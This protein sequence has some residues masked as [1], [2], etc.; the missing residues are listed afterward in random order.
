MINRVEDRATASC[1]QTNATA[2]LRTTPISPGTTGTQRPGPPTIRVS[3]D[4]AN[5]DTPGS[6][7]GAYK[8][9]SIAFA[10]DQTYHKTPVDI[11]KPRSPGVFADSARSDGN[12][13]TVVTALG[14]LRPHESLARSL[15]GIGSS[16]LE[17]Q[18]RPVLQ[19]DSKI[20][21]GKHISGTETSGTLWS[22]LLVLRRRIEK[23]TPT[24]DGGPTGNYTSTLCGDCK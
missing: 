11:D 12:G 3:Q 21:R 5:D 23:S 20:D 17:T 9:L 18:L 19:L 2:Q 13:L 14:W 7:A 6:G 22:T 1:L 15:V 8:Q 4:T 10:E 16:F 24:R